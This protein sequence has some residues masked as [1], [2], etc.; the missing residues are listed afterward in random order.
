M[1]N[2]FDNIDGFTQ[3]PETKEYMIVAQYGD[4][5]NLLSYLDRNINRLTWKMKLWHLHDI[6]D[7]LWDIH[8]TGIVH[9]NL[10]GRNIILHKNSHNNNKFYT[11]AR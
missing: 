2:G 6:A 3:D 4:K 10:H 9:C 1:S 7:D 8:S 11:H 5:G